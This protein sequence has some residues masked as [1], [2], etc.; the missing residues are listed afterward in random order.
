MEYSSREVSPAPLLLSQ[1]LTANRMFLLHHGPSLNDLY[2]KVSRDKFCGILDRF[3]SRFCRN[4]EVLLHGNP[5]VEVFGG[6]K[7]AAGGELGVGV[8]EEDWGSGEREVLE[9]LVR[10]TEGLVDL[11][12]SRFGQAAPP[13]PDSA[14][15]KPSKETLAEADAGLPWLGCGHL[16]DASDG[17][18][19]GGTGAIA[20]PALRNISEWVQQIYTYGEHAYG[21]KDNPQR[22]PPRKRRRRPPPADE[23]AVEATTRTDLRKKA[24]EQS[25]QQQTVEEPA[26]EDT[27]RTELR[28]KALEQSQ[29]QQQQQPETELAVELPPDPRPQMHDRVA[30]H[31]HATGTSTPQVASHP[32]IPP[33]IV[34]AA[35]DSLNAAARAA[36]STKAEPTAN[37]ES[38]SRFG[39]SDKW[40]GYL[41]LGLT[42]TGTTNT[43]RS[44]SPSGR[45][46][47]PRH[48][49]SSSSRTLRPPPPTS[50][51]SM[52]L[53]KAS[54]IP[55]DDESGPMQTLDPAPDG[56]QMHAQIDRQIY[57]ENRGHFLIGFKG[58][59]GKLPTNDD[60]NDDLSDT[61]ADR[62]M[63][64]TIQIEMP[65]QGPSYDEYQRPG[66]PE[67]LPSDTEDDETPS[68]PK[69]Q[70]F[71]VLVYIHRPFIYTLLF[72][73]RSPVLQMTSFYGKLHSHLIPLH[74]PLLRSTSLESVAQRIADAHA[75]PTSPSTVATETASLQFRKSS[76]VFDLVHDPLTLT[77]HTSIPNIPDPGTPAAEGFATTSTG[78]NAPPVWTRIEA[79]NVHS[80]ILNTLVA[81]KPNK[82][83]TERTSKT[84]RGWWIVW[85]RIPGS[86][87][88]NGPL[89]RQRDGYDECRT[90]FLVRK[91]SDG[92]SS[93][94]RGQTGGSRVSSMTG[95]FGLGGLGGFGMGGGPASEE[96]EEA[97]A[98]AVGWGLGIDARKYVESLLSLNR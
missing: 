66:S 98:Q 25:Q 69:Y 37:K 30:S 27:T 24:I 84:S 85:M 87:A 53:Q 89:G 50:K 46:G 78:R 31:D 94:V 8:G 90:A 36:T 15:D 38:A 34:S 51:G 93:Q 23:P 32:G 59:L 64:R 11:T 96:R 3:W 45:P 19:F 2:V 4:W 80:Q 47:P 68:G 14:S 49:S 86:P 21:V 1:V 81:V 18:I 22:A 9:D 16:P 67:T 70:R 74:K 52:R 58:D 5:A 82:L 73:Q 7:L 92:V 77:T 44:S 54:N 42:N 55:E 97:Q 62:V 17:V 39:I 28:K 26:V 83:E 76:P 10:Q 43:S 20:R 6:M 29:Q 35:E 72:E 12:V 63:L 95:M 79:I 61:E 57:Q 60:E 71:R 75:D 40:M 33:P 88:D 13:E 65:E 91:A 56:Y 48:T 41:T